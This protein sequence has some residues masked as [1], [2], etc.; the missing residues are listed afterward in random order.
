MEILGIVGLLELNNSF[1]RLISRADTAE[2]KE[3]MVSQQKL[4]KLKYKV[5]GNRKKGR[6]VPTIKWADMSNWR[7][8]GR[9]DREWVEEILKELMARTYKL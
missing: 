1:D 9:K 8:R 6:T 4:S 5:G 7:L 2:E 3:N